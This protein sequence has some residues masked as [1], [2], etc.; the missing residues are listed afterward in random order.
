MDCVHVVGCGWDSKRRLA[1][2]LLG[3][4][5]LEH[6]TTH[7]EQRWRSAPT[8]KLPVNVLP[9][10]ALT[11]RVSETEIV[12]ESP[13]ISCHLT[14]IDRAPANARRVI[15]AAS[16]LEVKSLARL[17]GDVVTNAQPTSSICVCIFDDT[18]AYVAM[19]YAKIARRPITTVVVTDCPTPALRAFLDP[20]LVIAGNDLVQL[21]TILCWYT[22]GAPLN[23]ERL[24]GRAVLLT[25]ASKPKLII[26]GSSG[27]TEIDGDAFY[28][29][30]EASDAAFDYLEL[31]GPW[32]KT[33]WVVHGDPSA[34]PHVHTRH[35][36]AR[37]GDYRDSEAWRFSARVG[38]FVDAGRTFGSQDWELGM[39]AGERRRSPTYDR[40]LT[41][42]HNPW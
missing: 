21:W 2:S 20:S 18:G 40:F 6:Y 4:D 35:A 25:T 3:V 13:A 24:R 36:I 37:V 14:L 19:D 32:E 8:H 42:L 29:S 7:E 38:D 27:D 28:A 31:Q 33:V 12:I 26:H 39:L 23:P 22:D 34:H 15:V 41:W 17:L 30:L 9:G 5:V 10:I 1:L 11:H 16:S